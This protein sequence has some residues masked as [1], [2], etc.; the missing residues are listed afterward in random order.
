MLRL[1][2]AALLQRERREVELERRGVLS[3]AASRGDACESL[4]A[5]RLWGEQSSAGFCRLPPCSRLALIC[6]EQSG[7]DM[8]WLRY[9][10]VSPGCC[11]PQLRQLR[12]GV[13]DRAA[14]ARLTVKGPGPRLMFRC[15]TIH[16][17]AC[18]AASA[19]PVADFAGN[20][21]SAARLGLRDASSLESTEE[22]CRTASPS[23][24]EQAKL[25]ATS[26]FYPYRRCGA[27]SAGR[28]GSSV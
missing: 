15:F 11:P 8:L 12:I 18:G 19:M 23:R 22:D 1:Q 21:Q 7:N 27:W 26:L 24:A 10:V 20:S 16:P 14:A 2:D 28:A 9:G 25:R 4:C 6:C 5:S 3:P 17:P 13:A